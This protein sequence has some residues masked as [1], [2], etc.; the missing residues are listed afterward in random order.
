ME[1]KLESFLKN[2][3]P[4][5]TFCNSFYVL[6]R[7]I[8][9][10]PKDFFLSFVRPLSWIEI[11]YLDAIEDNRHEFT[12]QEQ[13][14]IEEGLVKLQELVTKYKKEFSLK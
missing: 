1:K 5:G 9:E 4:I 10:P 14:L 11:P 13:L 12:A 2:E 8:K 6:I 7:Q 3:I